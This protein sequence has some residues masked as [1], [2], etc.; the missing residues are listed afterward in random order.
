VDVRAAQA[1]KAERI[2][3]EVSSV[4]SLLFTGRAAAILTIPEKFKPF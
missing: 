3:V 2:K 1:G 4:Y